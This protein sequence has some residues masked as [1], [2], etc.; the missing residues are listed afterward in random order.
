MFVSFRCR[1]LSVQVMP[2]NLVHFGDSVLG[3]SI[4]V[5]IRQCDVLI[6]VC[7]RWPLATPILLSLPES[8]AR[9]IRGFSRLLRLRNRILPKATMYHNCAEETQMQRSRKVTP[10]GPDPNFLVH[11]QL[12]SLQ[13]TMFIGAFLPR[14]GNAKFQDTLKTSCLWRLASRSYLGSHQYRGQFSFPI[15]I[16]TKLNVAWLP[17]VSSC[18]PSRSHIGRSTRNS[19]QFMTSSTGSAKGCSDQRFRAPPAGYTA[20]L[21]TMHQHRAYDQYRYRIDS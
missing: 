6:Y 10:H 1:W 8:L 13:R 2:K 3:C 11:P 20:Q 21:L 4:F 14:L 12:Q 5:R 18:W 19:S 7:F 9:G 16:L 17:F 15:Q